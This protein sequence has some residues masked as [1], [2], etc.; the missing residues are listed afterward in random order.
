MQTKELQGQGLDEMVGLGWEG[1]QLSVPKA[2]L[3][4]LF[5]LSTA[6]VKHARTESTEDRRL[7]MSGVEVIQD[8]S[9]S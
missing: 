6:S 9:Q 1:R 7:L 4:G 2:A 5:M 8:I 3:F